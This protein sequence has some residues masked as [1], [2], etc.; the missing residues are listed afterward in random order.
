VHR[1]EDG[2]VD[3]AED[4]RR[5]HFFFGAGTIAFFGAIVVAT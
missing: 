1:G 3:H 2:D 4:N 5:D